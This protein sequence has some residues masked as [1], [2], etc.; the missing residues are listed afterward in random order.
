MDDFWGRYHD[1]PG[2]LDDIYE[3]EF[4]EDLNPL[5]QEFDDDDDENDPFF[6]LHHNYNHQNPDSQTQL[7]Q[8]SQSLNSHSQL[9]SQ[10]FSQTQSHSQSL[11]PIQNT[12]INKQIQQNEKNGFNGK[13]FQIFKL[14]S[15]LQQ[16]EVVNPVIV[17]LIFGIIL[18]ISLSSNEDFSFIW[19]LRL[20]SEEWKQCLLYIWLDNTDMMIY[21]V[22]FV[23]LILCFFVFIRIFS[24]NFFCWEY[25]VTTCFLTRA[26]T[27]IGIG[28]TI[29]F[30]IQLNG[31]YHQYRLRFNFNLANTGLECFYDLFICFMCFAC[32]KFCFLFCFYLARLCKSIFFRITKWI[33]RKKFGRGIKDR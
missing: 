28:L 11:T 23:F 3:R 9:H 30:F 21:L 22:I 1:D 15:S 29:Y 24:I 14:K 4:G 31:V 26:A 18:F 33:N 10:T 27:G 32:E 5:N 8:D 6:Q 20:I 16:I 13:N 7:V 19:R 2:A 12:N 17:A 25:P